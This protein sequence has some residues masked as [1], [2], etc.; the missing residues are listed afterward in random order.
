MSVDLMCFQ[1]RSS[2]QKTSVKKKFWGWFSLRGTDSLVSDDRAISSNKYIPILAKRVFPEPKKFGTSGPQ[3]IPRTQE[4]EEFLSDIKL[5]CLEWPENSPHLVPIEKLW[6][7]RKDKLRKLDTV[8][9][10]KLFV[11]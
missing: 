6:G 3:F 11:Q 1:S 4:R 2:R 9:R 8:T 10:E 7:V 5:A